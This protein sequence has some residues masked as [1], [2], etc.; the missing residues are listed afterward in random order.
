MAPYLI[1]VLAIRETGRIYRLGG[2]L[3]GIVGPDIEAL[4]S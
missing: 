3:T 2:R 1:L 4:S